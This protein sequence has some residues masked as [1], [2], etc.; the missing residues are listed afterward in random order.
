MCDCQNGGFGKMAETNKNQHKVLF[1]HFIDVTLWVVLLVFL[2][3]HHNFP[4][5]QIY[6]EEVTAL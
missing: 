4:L 5:S 2:T 6:S 1:S 3:D